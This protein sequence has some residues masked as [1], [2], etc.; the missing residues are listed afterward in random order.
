[1]NSQFSDS[2][3]EKNSYSST[4]NQ[5]KFKSDPNINDKMSA[6]QGNGHFTNYSYD[7]LFEAFPVNTRISTRD[8]NDN[9]ILLPGAK[10]VQN[11]N[12]NSSDFIHNQYINSIKKQSLNATISEFSPGLEKQFENTRI[13]DSQFSSNIQKEYINPELTSID[14]LNS[15]SDRIDRKAANNDRMQALAPLSMSR[16]LPMTKSVPNDNKHSYPKN[17][18]YQ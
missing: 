12:V 4:F 9:T 16:A 15:F 2:Y 6:I 3:N 17:T 14:R 13:L 10:V 7:T 18:R 8:K 5:K 1:M 11:G